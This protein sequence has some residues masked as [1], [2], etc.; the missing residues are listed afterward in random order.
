MVHS[1]QPGQHRI[2]NIFLA[3]ENNIIMM[4]YPV[5]CAPLS[6]R[7]PRFTPKIIIQMSFNGS[8]SPSFS[9]SLS[10]PLTDSTSTALFSN[11]S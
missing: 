6:L 4:D 9:L 2:S 8:L 11:L 10:L 7:A 1:S 3:F 5:G